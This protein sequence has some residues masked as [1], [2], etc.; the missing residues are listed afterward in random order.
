MFIVINVTVQGGALLKLGATRKEKKKKKRNWVCAYQFPQGNH[1]ELCVCIHTILILNQPKVRE[2]N[3]FE[4]W[5]IKISN[6]PLNK[7]PLGWKERRTFSI[8]AEHSSKSPVIL[9][10]PDTTVMFIPLPKDDDIYPTLHIYIYIHR[11]RMRGGD[12]S[13]QFWIW[14]IPNS[15]RVLSK[16]EVMQHSVKNAP[17]PVLFKLVPAM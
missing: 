11:V 7:S 17:A 8:V 5:W 12:N 4:V 1:L 2:E 3:V 9:V 6:S 14:Y 15:S 16:K 10:L 13:F